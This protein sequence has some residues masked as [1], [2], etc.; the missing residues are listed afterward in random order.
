[1]NALVLSP[2]V[3]FLFADASADFN[4]RVSI[5]AAAGVHAIEFWGWRNKDV[6]GLEHVL[7]ATDVHVTAMVVDPIVSMVCEP[8]QFVTAVRET[9]A[10]A[11]RLG[12]STIIIASGARDE[13]ASAAEQC[14]R[15]VAALRDALPFAE[16]SGVT[17]ALEAVNAFD[18][19]MAYVSRLHHAV[20]L[21]D[22][23]GSTALGIVVDFYHASRMN[24]LVAETI[25]N[26][27]GL[28]RHMQLA[29]L[30]HREEPS[31]G[32]AP[33]LDT[34]RAF[35]N[36]GYDGPIG[37]EYRPQLASAASWASVRAF[38]CEQLEATAR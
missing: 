1:M 31:A 8:D 15:A 6:D 22:A 19:P 20:T 33:Y 5:A 21:V 18:H 30:P 4:E 13:T 3:E 28:I 35:R 9:A 36:G 16:A 27:I 24:E 26:R 32:S 17:L 12:A 37:L 38:L 14:G 34:V 23:V 29:G 10:V 11:G 25:G 2:N 7:R